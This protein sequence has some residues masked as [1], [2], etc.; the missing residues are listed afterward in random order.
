MEDNERTEIINEY[1]VEEVETNKVSIV[2]PLLA[3]LGII[4]AGIGGFIFYKKRKKSKYID[5]PLKEVKKI[6]NAEKED[7]QDEE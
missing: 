7:E 5:I 2:K 1:D 3:V 4:G 6:D